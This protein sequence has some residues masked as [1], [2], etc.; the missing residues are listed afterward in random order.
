MILQRIL[1]IMAVVALTLGGPAGPAAVVAQDKP[2]QGDA[3]RDGEAQAQPDDAAEAPPAIRQD[4]CEA[5]RLS[6]VR[7]VVGGTTAKRENGL[8]QAE[9]L[10]SPSYSEADRE[11]DRSLANGDPC[12]I[13]L[14]LRADYE[15]A[16]KCGGSWL[17]DGFVITAAHCVDNIPGFNGKEGN[18]LTDRRVRLGTL[19]L[20]DTD[21]F[22]AIDSVMIHKDYNAKRKLDDI[23]LIRL[24]PDGRLGQFTADKRLAAIPLMSASDP[25]F[26]PDEELLVTGWGWMG[27]RDAKAMVTRLDKAGNVQRN[28]ST[29]RQLH[30]VWLPDGLCQ[31]EYGE[32][33]DA[34]MM[35]ATSRAPDGS[36][37]LDKDSCQGDSGGPLTR[38]DARGRRVLAGLVS[39]GAGCGAGKPG[40]YT[41]VSA[42]ADWI[43]R[44]KR[45]AAS[46]QVVRVAGTPVR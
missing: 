18:V 5:R 22:F 12:K 26:R 30:L 45:A 7:R 46:G 19:S 15:L 39:G 4:G 16:H 25:K 2:A 23:A 17:G 40:V 31:A 20:L 13:Y 42:Y 9:I 3:A 38:V 29:L 44:A 10:S 43:K 33:Y 36:I 6:S 35:C 8:W 32:F 24:R 11:Y 34:G 27:S 1:A 14:D 28:P 37:A 21:G 41:R